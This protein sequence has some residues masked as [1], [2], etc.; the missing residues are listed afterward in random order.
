MATDT[1]FGEVESPKPANH[2]DVV[3]PAMQEETSVVAEGAVAA[4]DPGSC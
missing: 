3:R 4:R 1:L 2:P